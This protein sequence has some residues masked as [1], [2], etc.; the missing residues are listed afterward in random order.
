ML[1]CNDC[2]HEQEVGKF[3]G[4]C[5]TP[6]EE[7]NTEIS[8]EA[9]QEGIENEEQASSKITQTE[10]ETTTNEQESQVTEQPAT[11]ASEQ[12]ASTQ[13]ETK[14]QAAAINEAQAEQAATTA[15]ST[16][17]IDTRQEQV[18]SQQQSGGGQS[19]QQK[20][21]QAYDQTAEIKEHMQSYWNF[22]L[23]L[24]K[25]PTKA[26]DLSEGKFNY[27]LINF[28]LLAIFYGITII[29]MTK[30]TVG[31]LG[32]MFTTDIPYL[33][34]FF[35]TSILTL[36][37]LATVIVGTFLIERTMIKQESFKTVVAQL[38]GLMTPMIA[39]QLVAIIFALGGSFVLTPLIVFVSLFFAL[40]ILPTLYIYEKSIVHQG[41][42]KVYLGMGTIA[43]NSIL[44]YLVVRI[45]AAN[46]IQD[47]M[48]EL[49]YYF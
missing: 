20:N 8:A 34:L 4:K 21:S 24:L 15:A 44:I 46:L 2:G 18:G 31:L 10:L 36:V 19:Q 12:V 32:G 29:A 3:C 7:K 48:N 39:L 40:L 6:L 26:M 30:S 45:I 13:V 1:I 43:V 37:L 27:G 49:N 14:Q 22:I 5:G 33:G 41:G 47:L 25:N 38:G 23:R 17:Q 28:S 9:E 42:Q 16:E 35:M 11:E